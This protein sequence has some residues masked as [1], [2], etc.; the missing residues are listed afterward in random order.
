M[1]D[2]HFSTGSSKF[3]VF[4][5]GILIA[6]YLVALCFNLPQQATAIIV[7]TGAGHSTV[8]QSDKGTAEKAVEIK[9]KTPPP[10]WMVLPFGL[11]LGV[12]AVF[13]L[14]SGVSHW[15]E[16][17]L[18][19]FY[20]AAALA[21]LT[22]G[23]YLWIHKQ[24]IEAHWPAHHVAL[25]SESGLGYTLTW[26]VFANA[27]LGEYIPFIVLLFSL[28]TITGGI[29]L[30]GDLPAHSFT[31]A[32][33]LLVGGVLASFI[34]TTG[35]AM[36]LIR[37]LLETNSERK[38]VAHTVVFFIFVVC[39]CGGCLLPLGDPPLFLG[40]LLGVPFLYTIALWKE[41]LFVNGLLIAIYYFWDLFWYYPH[42][43]TSD[44]VRDETQVRRLKLSGLWPNA[45]LLL[46]MVL[47][48]AFL[49]PGKSIPGVNWHPWLYLREV[50]QLFLVAV[51]LV[52]G[53]QRV[54][55][56]NK[57]N[58]HAIIEV[59]ALFFGIFITMQP[60]LQ[61]LAIRGSSLG[62]SEQ[63]HFYWA[64]GMLSSVLDNAPTY[65][66]FFTTAQALTTK[67]G[68]PM[69]IAGVSEPL[70]AAISL[71]AVFMGANTYIGNG[72]N[73]MVKAV[74][75][76]S[77]VKMPGFFGYMLYSGAILIPIFILT[78]YLFF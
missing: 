73:F 24:P 35:A 4:G 10:L 2:V 11:M 36:L 53:S 13:P 52:L 38:H 41:W 50:V 14:L 18:H 45:F 77:G 57:F 69:P 59:A 16:S 20:I 63:W 39:N 58:Y 7:A 3:V 8:E 60:A 44:I 6:V 33:F 17:N 27:M 40:Y 5:I 26:D 51:S 75:E 43:E 65:V 47:S 15:W 21:A 31:N 67:L 54:R 22:L 30:E 37:P 68:L 49:D 71:G 72:P 9:A 32:M 34:G 46:G 76:K 70:L 61:I 55:E 78:T 25:H 74:A 29:R 23:Y 1:S 19:R 28:Y 66:V 48:V 62:L 64:T 56:D 42:E 12:I